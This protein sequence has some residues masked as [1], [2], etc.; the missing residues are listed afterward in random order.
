[1]VSE[2]T[3]EATVTFRCPGFPPASA[4]VAVRGSA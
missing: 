1:V 3:G 2:F 4:T